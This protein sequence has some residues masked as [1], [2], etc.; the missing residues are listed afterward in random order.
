MSERDETYR[1]R[2]QKVAEYL[3]RRGFAATR[4]VDFEGTRDSSIRYLTGQPGDALLVIGADASSVLVP[5]DLNMAHKMAHADFILPYT[6]FGRKAESAAE[7]AL[8]KLGISAGEKVEFSA[9]TPYPVF[10]DNVAAL[11]AWDLICERGG[12]DEAILSL[13]SVKDEGELEIYRRAAA[14][15]NAVI[16]GVERGVR[17]CSLNSETDVALFIEREGRSGGA[18]GMGFETLAA[19]PS[20]SFGIHAFPPYG[21]GPFGGQGFS[22]LDFG[23][24]LEG[25]TTDVTMTFVRGPLSQVQEKMLQL[26]EEAHALGIRSCTAGTPARTVA[27]KIDKLFAEASLSMPHSL[28]HGVGLEAHEAPGLN[29]RE[30]NEAVLAPGNI[31]TIEPGLYSPKEGGVR[32]ED[33]VLVTDEGPVTLTTSRIVRL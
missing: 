29:L 33:D 20:R 23:L 5:W 25:Y 28:G 26:V 22:I 21:S 18:E 24:V 13:R 32:L 31:V 7:A 19:G 27:E 8:A 4:L 2:R 16:D 15:T 17:S 14:L 3:K 1:R 6:D 30:E 9:S 11:S 10:V 12:V